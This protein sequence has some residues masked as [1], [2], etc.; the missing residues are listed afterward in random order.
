MPQIIFCNYLKLIL[1][2]VMV[3]IIN[4]LA[5]GSVVSFYVLHMN[6]RP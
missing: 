3:E 6:L 4:K 1:T 2:P 5:K